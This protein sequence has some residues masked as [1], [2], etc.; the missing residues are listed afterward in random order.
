[1]RS[2]LSALIS[3]AAAKRLT[4]VEVLPDRSNQHEFHGV[5]Q[6][7][8]LFGEARRTFD[9]RFVYLGEDDEDITSA[10]GFVT[11]YDA[12][13]DHPRRS[14]FRLYF[15]TTEVSGRLRER[16][17]LV[18]LRR[19]D[20]SV[21][22]AFAAEGSTA[23]HQLE[24]LFGLASPQQRFEV[25]DISTHD[26]DVGFAAREILAQLGIEAAISPPAEE[27]YLEVLLGRFGGRFPATAAFSAF[28]RDVTDDIEPEEDP[29]GALIAWLEREE[30]LF[31]QLERHLV[32][33]RLRRGFEED[34]DAFVEF[35]LSVQN[36]RK[37]RVGYALE[38]HF[39]AILQANGIQYSRG[40]ITERS[41]RPDFVFP[42][43]AAYRDH[44]CPAGSLAMLGVKSTCKDRWRQILAE[45]DRV[46]VKHLLTLEPGISSTQ[47]DEMRARQVVLVI[48]Q[49]L[50]E[51]FSPSQRAEM[52]T[53]S[54]FLEVLKER[55]FRAPVR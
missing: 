44:Q 12:R 29:D 5:Q 18:V 1:M 46:A 23:E 36:R 38:N 52:L 54:R 10:T 2:Q 15:P 8:T 53:V 30:A 49:G 47:T 13:E 24:W 28:A 40:Q 25:T 3:G 16:D 21:L 22:I 7:K 33:E 32:L 27:S 14:E 19:T 6:L 26:S 4:A 35:S 20:D 11:W 50:Q 37:S 55:Q 45:A 43:I 51:T 48:P 34:V 17:L 42:S 39:E 31:R 9:A 41:S